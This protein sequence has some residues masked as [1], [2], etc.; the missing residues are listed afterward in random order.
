MQ[1][2]LMPTLKPHII[3]SSFFFL[4]IV[5]SYFIM[6]LYVPIAYILATYEDF[7]GEWA[8]VF[9]F[10]TVFIMSFRL[11]FVNSKFRFYFTILTLAS[12]Y[13]VMEEISWGQRIFDITSPDFFKKHNLQ[14][15]TNLLI[16]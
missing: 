14:T 5:C 3:A 9:L 11:T 2:V 16:D 7:F 1:Y 13:T 12:F 6:A 8:Q 15:E 4:L 10:L